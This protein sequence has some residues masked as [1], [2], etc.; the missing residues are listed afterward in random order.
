MITNPLLIPEI[1]DR[2][3]DFVP[4]WKFVS[5]YRTLSEF[6]FYPHDTLACAL[7]CRTW[8]SIFYP[9]L[10]SVYD[11]RAMSRIPPS[12]RRHA[13]QDK[14]TSSNSSSR[15][16]S[17]ASVPKDLLTLQSPRFRIFIDNGPRQI[18]DIASFQCRQLMDLTLY[19]SFP[20]SRHLLSMNPHLKKLT[21]YGEVP[22]SG[23]LSDLDIDALLSLAKRNGRIQVRGKKG[24]GLE[25]LHLNQ[26]DVSEGRLIR[27]L[28]WLSKGLVRLTLKNIQGLDSLSL[29][30]ETP[31][32]GGKVLNEMENTGDEREDEEVEEVM[33]RG[34]NDNDAE[35]CTMQ[36]PTHPHHHQQQQQQQHEEEEGQEEQ[37]QEKQQRK[38]LVL[39]HLQELTI[40]C[41][42]VE[43]Q[44]L[45]EFIT[46]CCPKLTSLH[47]SDA[48][49]DDQAMIDS[50]ED[51]LAARRG[52]LQ[53]AMTSCGIQYRL[54]A[55]GDIMARYTE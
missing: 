22:F 25:E 16:I 5:C 47:L 30:H 45:L 17:F 4:S 37:E 2:V 19:G 38:S 31:T 42:W 15:N 13:S 21:W 23:M 9:T 55:N 49:M 26:W 20:R 40:D 54:D 33:E 50:L 7:V 46:E 48:M 14:D 8:Y 51:A 44:V 18:S 12:P 52:R 10:W 24:M 53:K 1:L 28:Q 6:E 32:T 35:Q 27:V 11:G 29:P 3:S 43:N 39:D 41:E 36:R 34:Q